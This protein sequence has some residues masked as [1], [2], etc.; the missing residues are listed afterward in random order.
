[1]LECKK[2]TKVTRFQNYCLK[3]QGSHAHACHV[4][5]SETSSYFMNYGMLV[6]L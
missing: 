4:E 6:C 2:V 1:M 5:R 3:H